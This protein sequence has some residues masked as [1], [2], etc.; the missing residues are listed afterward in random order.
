MLI[1]GV[2]VA[3]CPDLGGRYTCPQT[4]WDR[5][6]INIELK[7][8]SGYVYY[9][10]YRAQNNQTDLYILSP[11]PTVK[12]KKGNIIILGS[13]YCEQGQFLSKSEWIDITIPGDSSKFQELLRHAFLDEKGDLVL[14]SELWFKDRR[15]DPGYDQ[16]RVICPRVKP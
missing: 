4:G 12:S 5:G 8:Q 6:A 13:N 14:L 9:Q 7:R 11:K 16:L 15:G 3:D 1:S 10:W 2:A